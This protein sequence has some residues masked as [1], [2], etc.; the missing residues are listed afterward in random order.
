[1]TRAQPGGRRSLRAVLAIGLAVALTSSHARAA[2]TADPLA[3]AGQL[4]EEARAANARGDYDAAIERLERILE[5]LP[6]ESG[7]ASTR[8]GIHYALA[9]N[10]EAAHARDGQ[11]DHLRAASAALGRYLELLGDALDPESQVAVASRREALDAR[12]DAAEARERL[13]AQRPSTP[14]TEAPPAATTSTGEPVE[15][16]EPVDHGDPARAAR[17]RTLQTAGA[18]LTGLGLTGMVTLAVGLAVGAQVDRAGADN[19]DLHAQ[20]QRTDDVYAAV[21]DDL[22]RQ[23]YRANTAAYLGGIG[24]GVLLAAGVTLL[25]FGLRE[26][27]RA[28]PRTSRL[29]SSGVGVWVQF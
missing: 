14:V 15:P 12:V 26:R 9:T 8:A 22:N 10:H 19:L 24:G 29:G 11:L 4:Y 2:P 1:M 6:Q 3:R 17:A 28:T 16:L 23:G 21:R 5:D 20:G 25:V 13:A 18:V 7:Y 27:R